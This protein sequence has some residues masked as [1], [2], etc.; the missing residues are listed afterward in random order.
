MLLQL[1][2]AIKCKVLIPLPDRDFDPTE[3]IVPWR[4]FNVEGWD[5]HFATEEA[6]LRPAAD[7]VT[8]NP[9]SYMSMLGC[10]A[11]VLEWY[12]QLQEDP[13]FVSPLKWNELD[14]SEFDLVVLP[15]GHA[16]GMKQYLEST[17]LQKKILEYW[18]TGKPIGAICHGTRRKGEKKKWE[19]E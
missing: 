16:A 10:D 2:N 12:A 1:G 9:P 13:H 18:K 4:L 11:E 5:V 19:S 6:L 7:E 3:V 14:T 8:C 15:G 17:V